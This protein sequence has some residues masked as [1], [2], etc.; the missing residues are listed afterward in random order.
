MINPKPISWDSKTQERY[1]KLLEYVQALTRTLKN[2]LIMFRKPLSIKDLKGQ[3]D[4]LKT[5]IKKIEDFLPNL[6]IS[7]TNLEKLKDKKDE[8]DNVRKEFVKALVD[9]KDALIMQI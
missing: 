5:L 2:L 8:L 3:I 7:I 6:D 1:K 4:L 9:A